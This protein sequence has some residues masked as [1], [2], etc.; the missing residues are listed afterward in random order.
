MAKHRYAMDEAK[1]ER[2]LREGRGQGRLADY[3]P[4]LTIQDVPST[5]RA[6]RCLGRHTERLHH[7]LSDIEAACFLMLDWEDNVIDIREAFPLDR[8]ITRRIAQQ[9]GITHPKDPKTKV[10]IVVT[11]DFLVD[12]QMSG[13]RE[14]IGISAK[15]A[16]DLND[17]RVVEKQE[18]ERRACIESV[19]PTWYAFTDRNVPKIRVK[20]LR[21][22]TEMYSLKGVEEGYPGYWTDRCNRVLSLLTSQRLSTI[23]Q[24]IGAAENSGHFAS[25]ETLTVIRHLAANKRIA[26]NFTENFSLDWP[27]SWIAPINSAPLVRVK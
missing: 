10:D 5:G 21:W 18:L 19:T 1:I 22:L 20:T 13:R 3:K 16:S 24:L 6:S 4:F 26:M 25:G 23:R 9:M 15:P 12:I 27:I 11:I 14:C 8:A 2:F 17:D 7:L